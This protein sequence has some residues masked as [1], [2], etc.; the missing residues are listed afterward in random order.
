MTLVDTWSTSDIDLAALTALAEGIGPRLPWENDGAEMFDNGREWMAESRSLPARIGH[1]RAALIVAAVN[2]LPGLLAEVEHWKR[3]FESQS[4]ARVEVEDVLDKAL[5]P[6][7]EDGAGEGLAADV[8]L[9]VQQRDQARAEAV[10]LRRE[11]EHAQ[12]EI[13]QLS[14]RLQDLAERADHG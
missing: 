6:N 5:G 2:A 10:E 4:N 11:V 7:E 3:L 1:N 14:G 8:A 9:V 13:E 12:Q